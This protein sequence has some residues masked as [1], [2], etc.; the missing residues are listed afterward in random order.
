MKPKNALVVWCIL[1]ILC[2]SWA[3]LLVAE[4]K[5]TPSPSKQ[6]QV[7][8]EKVDSLQ[9]ELLQ[10]KIESLQKDLQLLA[11][12]LCSDAKFTRESCRVNTAAGLIT[13]IKIEQQKEVA[14]VPDK[15]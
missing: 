6:E 12:K 11:S 2:C 5:T 15:K 3:A 8:I 14:K 13:G 9:I 7:A 10:I 4:D 1:M